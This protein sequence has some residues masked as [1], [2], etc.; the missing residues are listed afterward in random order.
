MRAYHLYGSLTGTFDVEII[1]LASPAVTPSTREIRPGMI[2]RVVP[3]TEAH[4]NK[5]CE[6]SRA[7][8]L[9]V[10]DIVASRLMGL[11]PTTLGRY[12]M[13]C[14]ERQP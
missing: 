4:D 3:R 5:E 12:T 13:P 1:S 2:E 6:I 11:T 10:T 7:V 8:G 9:P 14:G